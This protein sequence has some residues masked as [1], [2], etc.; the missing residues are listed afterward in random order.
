MNLK[1]KFNKFKNTRFYKPVSVA[2]IAVSG[3]ILVAGSAKAAQYGITVM[4]EQQDVL[5]GTGDN[6]TDYLLYDDVLYGD[7]A[8]SYSGVARDG[9][10]ITLTNGDSESEYD[11]DYDFVNAVTEYGNSTSTDNLGKASDLESMEYNITKNVLAEVEDHYGT[12]IEGA[13]GRDGKDGKDGATGKA[14]ATGKTGAT[15]ATGKAGPA[16]KTG[17]AGAT[18]K[19]GPAGATGKTGATGATGENGKNAYV[20]YAP[21]K[22]GKPD[23]TKVTTTADANSRWIGTYT[24]QTLNTAYSDESVW[25]WSKFT[26]ANIY[27]SDGTLYITN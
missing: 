15:G 23:Y 24:G 7:V 6:S 14:G 27:Y 20:R 18:G 10:K 4:K 16:G 11:S 12:V 5:S 25:S 22:N 2:A 3:V 19:T 21:D 1:A 26:N 8:D 13:A 9:T 17:A